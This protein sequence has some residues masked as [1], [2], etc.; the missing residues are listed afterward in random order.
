M[1]P[2]G[3]SASSAVALVARPLLLHDPDDVESAR[4]IGEHLDRKLLAA[5]PVRVLVG[6][7][8]Q[9]HLVPLVGQ[10]VDLDHR[11]RGLRSREETVH[12]QRR[13]RARLAASGRPDSRGAEGADQRRSVMLA[14]RALPPGFVGLGIEIESLANRDVASLPPAAQ[15]RQIVTA[16]GG[17]R[18][19]GVFGGRDTATLTAA[20]ATNRPAT[21][22]GV[23][24]ARAGR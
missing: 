9:V 22:N 15:G 23:P 4:I 6:G 12:A 10:I 17:K 16:E 18:Q 21:F 24:K 14:P 3:S 11:D 13:R 20:I 8:W 5:A 7:R 19:V 1:H 2:P